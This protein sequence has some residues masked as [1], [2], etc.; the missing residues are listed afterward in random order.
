MN[1]GWGDVSEASEVR[2]LA[3]VKARASIQ[4]VDDR[5]G[6]TRPIPASPYKFRHLASEVRA[7]APHLGE[8]NQAVLRQWLDWSDEAINEVEA[9]LLTTTRK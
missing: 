3:A 6:G 2:E 9:A 4:A 7:G 8:H 1:I 5:A